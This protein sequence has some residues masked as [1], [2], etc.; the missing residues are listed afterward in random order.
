VDHIF[1]ST[2]LS[3]AEKAD[4]LGRNAAKLFDLKT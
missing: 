4:I 2:S 1:A 3:D